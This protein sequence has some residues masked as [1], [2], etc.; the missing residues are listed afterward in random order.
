MKT[1][2]DFKS[3]VVG[4]LVGIVV[5]LLTGAVTSSNPVGK[6]QVDVAATGGGWGGMAVIVDT[7]TGEAWAVD[8]TKNF[9]A[10]S[11]KFWDAK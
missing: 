2:I 11:D 9:N 1:Q 7:Q 3:A 8:F 5:I 10:K 6:Y 4:L